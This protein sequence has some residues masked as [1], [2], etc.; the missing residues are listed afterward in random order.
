M[1]AHR[2]YAQV[3][4]CV[5]RATHEEFLEAHDHT[6]Q[7]FLYPA[8]GG[9]DLLLIFTFLFIFIP[10]VPLAPLPKLWPM[11]HGDSEPLCS[12]KLTAERGTQ[13]K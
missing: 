4:S 13:S 9:D 6:W 7:L 1:L 5:R 11:E 10:P 12:R 3:P 8:P 2:Q